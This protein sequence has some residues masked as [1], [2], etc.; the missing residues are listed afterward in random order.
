M[1]E[2]DLIHL[3]AQMIRLM[4]PKRRRQVETE[5]ILTPEREIRMR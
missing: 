1:I 3:R 4:T 5:M 2:R